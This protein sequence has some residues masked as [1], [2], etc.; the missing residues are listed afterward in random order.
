M[1]D[2][3]FKQAR[4]MTFRTGVVLFALL[5]S[6]GVEGQGRADRQILEALYRATKG[7]SWTDSTN[8]LTD[9]PL[10]EWF[11][12]D[13]GGNGRVTRLA[14]PGN[15]L[16][17]PIPAEL[18]QLSRLWE[19]NLGGRWDSAL[20]SWVENELTGPIP[21]SL[22]EL[23]NLTWL[24][25]GDNDLTG[26]IPATLGNLAN[27][28]SLSL[29][30]N[31][32]TGAVP[33]WIG[34][35]LRL[36]EL[37]L[38]WNEF[39]GPIPGELGNLTSLR[40]LKLGWN[41]FTGPIPGELENL[42][43]LREL[44][45]D[46]N[47]LT[48]SIPAE[49]GNLVNLEVLRLRGN[50]L[51]GA[52]PAWLG[53]LGNLLDLSIRQN[54]L[55]GTIPS[56]LGALVNLRSLDLGRNALT[57]PV[58]AGMGNLPSL[59]YLA[60]DENRLTGA[61][62]GELGSLVNLESLRLS[63]NRL[64]G[65]LPQRLTL[66]SQLRVLTIG[67]TGACAP[68]DA[69]FQAWLATLEWF[70]G[71][72]CN[73]APEPVGAIP[74]QALTE[75]GPSASVSMED[76]FSDP[77]EDPLTSVAMSSRRSTV[78]T[79][80]SGDTVWLVPGSAGT[81]TVTVTA[82]DPDGL[83]ATQT[84][85]VTTVESPGPQ[86][87]REVL[88]LL[89]DG[90]GGASWAN[91]SSW[92][93]AAPLAEWYGVWTDGEGRVTELSLS[94]NGLRG[95]LPDALGNLSSL[96]RLGLG[97]NVLAGP[98]PSSLG[99]LSNLR[100]LFLSNNELTGRIP[101]ALGNLTNLEWLELGANELTG[102]IPPSLG[103][104][105]NLR[106]LF[107]SNNELTG[108]IPDALGNLTNLEWLNLGV[109]ELTGPIPSSLDELSNLRMLRLGV[110]ELT[111][112]IP[113]ALGNLT[114]LERLDLVFN[115]LAGPI[116]P[117]LGHLSNLKSL[118]LSWNWGLSGSLPAVA[119]P[120]LEEL[121]IFG[122]QTCAPVAWRDRL[123][124]IEFMGR[125]CEAR[126]DA[127]IVDVVVVY[128][129]AA[130]EEEGG[131]AAIEAVIDL[132]IAETNQAFSDSGVR[133]RLRLVES[134]EV[135][136]DETGDSLVDLLHLEEPSDGHLDE[137]HAM[138]DRVGADLVSLMVGESDVC[139]RA[140][141]PGAF[142]LTVRGC[143]FTH[144]LGH[145]MGL[146]HDRYQ[147]HHHEGG[148]SAHPAYGYVNQRALEADAPLSIG[149]VTIMS[150]LT[151]C[152]DVLLP[153]RG[154]F[155]FSNPRQRHDGDPVGTA[156][157]AGGSGVTG[158]ADAAAVLNATGP[159]VALW[160]DRPASANRQPA[161]AGILSDV[162]VSLHGTLNVDLSEAFV[163][164]D[165]DALTYAVSSSAPS[166]VTVSAAG[167]RVTLVAM[168]DGTAAIR[169]TASDPGGLS[170]S[171]SFTVTVRPSV[172][173]PFTDD[174]IRP[175]VTPVRAVHFTELRTR[176]DGLRRTAGLGRFPWTDP[177]LTVGVTAVKLTHLLE[178]RSALA[179]VYASSGRAAPIW[180]GPA[181]AAGTTPIRAAQLMELRA[182]VVALE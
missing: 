93:T 67:V 62:P 118:H 5:L 83:S 113:D 159:A 10:S 14:L 33:S 141:I 176:I 100:S 88:E 87:D 149:W 134:A 61:I 13:T 60:L 26:P 32:L 53:N 55:T 170:A 155:R 48:G 139:G 42:T 161:V 143:A 102:P 89:Y 8:W 158:P 64:S 117:A 101:D 76:Y 115:G 132:V 140:F 127:S 49:L 153:C 75:Y 4:P 181:P 98:I 99:R 171:Q 45:L 173:V 148:V 1:T 90:T 58:P 137:V 81:A 108:R 96:E 50:E 133:H 150:Y 164:P 40:G 34:D 142:S 52:V 31:R 111:G 126:A 178:L 182:A 92:S 43:S 179:A 6:T 136:Y 63:W 168:G 145:S 18:G 97:G 167:A 180:A 16:T 47:T 103:R 110:N 91:S 84:V 146:W 85:V 123:A 36:R 74:A 130:R 129:R 25:L 95:P 106:S 2:H 9:A 104:L 23:S 121:D 175:G 119:F 41:E 152:A 125:L 177:V 56:E 172:S 46:Y 162:S 73:R 138:R 35:L 131:A 54:L 151:Q 166:V 154:L 128:T 70:E 156:F 135:A 109:N 157:G 39:T 120:H 57:G 3:A 28:E 17:G 174:P 68:A 7:P 79:V 29:G 51:T 15:G 124:T 112:R 169:V 78:T 122:T 21:S 66:L 116:P 94:E 22:G 105:S 19:L 12:V 59:E 144:E 82:Q 20:E 86:T 37:D 147:V 30:G 114:N 72:T 44:G 11:G 163:D 69:E 24:A 107:L 80:V 38:A 65:A 77:D 160:R 27:L 165:G 71:D